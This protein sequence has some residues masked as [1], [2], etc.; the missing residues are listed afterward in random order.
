MVRRRR[1]EDKKRLRLLYWLAVTVV[2]LL[3]IWGFRLYLQRY[4][5]LHPEITQAVPWIEEELVVIEGVLLW[6][7]T[8]LTSPADGTVAYPQG[9]GPVR[10]GKGS[11]VAVVRTASGTSQVKAFQQ[12]YFVAGIDGNEESWKYS[13]LWPGSGPLPVAAP[14]TLMKDGARAARGQPLGKLAGQ[15]QELRFI[16]YAKAAGNMERQLKNTRLRVKMDEED[17]VS[18]AAVRVHHEMPDGR[19]KLYLNL[20]WFQPSQLM[21]RG[22]RLI[23]E[24]GRVEGALVPESALLRKNGAT[25]VYIVRGSRVMFRQIDGKAVEGGKFLATDGL[26]AGDAIV[27][28]ASAAREGRIQLW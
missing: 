11:V 19:V 5:Y 26:S 20:P 28:D 12:G 3:W 2:V 6:Q 10:V 7:E 14:L 4:N 23:I 16:G 21:S 8:V 1:H 24:A 17:T 25:G 18:T 13:E 22:C 9:R 15:P 27:E